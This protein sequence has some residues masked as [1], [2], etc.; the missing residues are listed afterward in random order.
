[1]IMKRTLR[2]AA[3]GVP[4]LLGACQQ[5]QWVNPNRPAADMTNDSAQCHISVDR[6][7]PYQPVVVQTSGAYV[8]SGYRSC[9]RTYYG[10]SCDY[11]PG[12]YVPPTYG[13]QDMNAVPRQNSY[14]ACL[15]AKGWRLV[16]AKTS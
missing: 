5:Y 1:M 15:S 8:T 3:L 12:S 16:P 6:M 9:Y 14:N 11:V 2:L 7:Y 4:L 13:T 10:R